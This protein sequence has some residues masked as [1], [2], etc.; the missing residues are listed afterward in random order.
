MLER[1]DRMTMAYGLEMRV[2][3]L[4]KALAPFGLALADRMKVRGRT[5]KWIVRQWAD[6][7]LPAQIRDRK[8]WGFRVPLDKWFRGRLRP[9]VGD[10]LS[11]RDGLCGTYGDRAAINA[12]VEAH[13]AGRIDAN[14]ELWTLLAAEIW[15]QDVY[16][17]AARSGAEMS[18]AIVGLN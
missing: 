11:S 13:Q 16:R 4:D 6:K 17:A 8:K 2:P 1:G 5:S 12:L 7:L 9:L 15:Y 14:L 10:Y 3:F 18:P